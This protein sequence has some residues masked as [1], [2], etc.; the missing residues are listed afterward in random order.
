MAGSHPHDGHVQERADIFVISFLAA[1]GAR[2]LA[3]TA[4][5][6]TQAGD[7][8][9]VA[10][11]VGVALAA[12]VLLAARSDAASRLCGSASNGLGIIATN[13]SCAFARATANHYLRLIAGTTAPLPPRR[14]FPVHSSATGRT[15]RMTCRGVEIDHHDPFI[16]CTGANKARIRL[17]S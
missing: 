13:A 11:A 14:T 10:R 5:A 17:V 9:R 12:A 2:R 8:A 4:M 3:L 15:Y 16:L 1:C 7:R 6:V